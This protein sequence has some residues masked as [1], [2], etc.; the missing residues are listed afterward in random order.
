MIQLD[1][2]ALLRRQRLRPA[3][4]ARIRD[5]LSHIASDAKVHHPRPP[6]PPNHHVVRLQ[7]AVYDSDGVCS[8]ESGCD[9]TGDVDDSRS[10]ER[11]KPKDI[12]QGFSVDKLQDKEQRAVVGEA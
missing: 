12:A 10:A 6:I 2:G 4:N 11:A 7:I 8:L 5:R 1:L 3:A 9:L